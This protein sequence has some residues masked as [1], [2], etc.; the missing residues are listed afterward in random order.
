MHV[1]VD[2]AGHRRRRAE[3]S[4]RGPRRITEAERGNRASGP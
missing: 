1:G 4:I 3:L 2:E